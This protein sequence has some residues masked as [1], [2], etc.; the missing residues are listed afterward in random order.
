MARSCRRTPITG[1]TKARSEKQDKQQANRRLRHHNRQLLASLD[2]DGLD[3]LV[4]L[5][6]ADVSDPWTMA[7]D[8]KGWSPF[9]MTED[10]ARYMRK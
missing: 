1:H 3:G 6:L 9:L 4:L 7:K 2:A 8:G 10:G 5:D